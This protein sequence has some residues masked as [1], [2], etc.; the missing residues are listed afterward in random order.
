MNLKTETAVDLCLKYSEDPTA[1]QVLLSEIEVTAEPTG[2]RKFFQDDDEQRQNMTV[3]ITRKDRT[4]SFEYG[5]SLNDSDAWKTGN[6]QPKYNSVLKNAFDSWQ[7]GTIRSREKQKS[8]DS[9]LYS[10]LACVSMDFYT[11][12]IFDDFCMETGYDSDSRKAFDLWQR[13]LKQSQGLRRIFS[14]EEV[15]CLP[16]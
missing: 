9:F 12:P 2:F 11:S 4:F 6:E 1:L 5:M 10:V 14:E 3:T 16:S 7:F 8:I 15:H 13:C